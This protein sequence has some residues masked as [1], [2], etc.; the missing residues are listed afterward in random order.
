MVG[1]TFVTDSEVDG[2]AEQAWRE[3]Y[4]R[5]V[6]KYEDFFVEKDS[7]GVSAGSNILL[8]GESFLKLR[9]VR[10]PDEWFLGRIDVKE[11][12]SVA[13]RGRTGKPTH[14]WLHGTFR[15]NVPRI[16]LFP[17]SDIARTLDVYFVPLW[18]LADV[19]AGSV[20][21]VAGWDEYL[22]LTMAMK[23]KDKEESDCSVI[24]AERNALLEVIE[25]SLTPLDAAEPFAV[26]QT[27]PRFSEHE[28]PFYTEDFG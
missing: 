21:F 9:G 24:M 7:I 16:E 11:M 8:V 27:A 10:H 2:Y 14:Y 28:D 23:M 4:M 3:F 1:S 12:P 19:T 20:R 25:K 5:L 26:V 6:S 18:S 17:T 15:G 22:V 13:M